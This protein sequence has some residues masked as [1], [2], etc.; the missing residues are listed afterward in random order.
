MLCWKMYKI[1]DKAI[2][3]FTKA[4]R[5]WKVEL[6]AGKEIWG[7]VKIQRGIFQGGAIFHYY[8]KY[9]RCHLITYLGNVLGAIHLQNHQKRLITLLLDAFIFKKFFLFIY[10]FFKIELW[11]FC[12]VDL[13]YWMH[14]GHLYRE[15]RPLT[16]PHPIPFSKATCWLRVESL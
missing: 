14:W 12:S 15:V 16:P 8:S 7:K 1:S 2:N 4:I 13:C 3:F 9:Q 10:F 11:L 6:T 5:N